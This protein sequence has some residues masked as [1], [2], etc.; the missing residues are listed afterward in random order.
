VGTDCQFLSAGTIESNTRQVVKDTNLPQRSLDVINELA[1]LG[2]SDVPARFYVDNDRRAFYRTIDTDPAYYLR[3]GVFYTSAG[4]TTAANP[5]SLK[6]GVVR[7]MDYPIKK[8]EYGAWLQDARDFYISEFE[9]SDAGVFYKTDEFD[10]S[11]LLA[12]QQ[13]YEKMLEDMAEREGGL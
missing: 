6:P 9:V 8:T 10:E 12:N 11:E 7:D 4:G 13:R 3:D 1:S 5:W 2:I